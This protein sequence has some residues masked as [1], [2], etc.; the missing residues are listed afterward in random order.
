M[1]SP[2]NGSP[3]DLLVHGRAL[4]VHLV[5]VDTL[6]PELAELDGIGVLFARGVDE[7]VARREVLQKKVSDGGAPEIVEGVALGVRKLGALR[8]ERRGERERSARARGRASVGT[9]TISNR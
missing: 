4:K 7:D 2:H 3:G 1:D 5:Q 6:V 9:R 8:T